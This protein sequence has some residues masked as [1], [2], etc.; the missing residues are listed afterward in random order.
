MPRDDGKD[1]FSPKKV[2]RE[3]I[4]YILERYGNL[5][6]KDIAKVLGL[7]PRTIRKTLKKLEDE[8]KIKGDKIGRSYIWSSL[9]EKKKGMMY[10]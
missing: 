5:K 4:M 8:E 6:T 1:S 7:K 9:E 2:R 3:V 10:F